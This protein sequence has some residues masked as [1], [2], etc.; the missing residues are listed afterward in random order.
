MKRT[1][2]QA[3]F[4]STE[5]TSKRLN[6]SAP[7]V[8]REGANPSLGVGKSSAVSLTLAGSS[9]NIFQANNTSIPKKS[10]KNQ[11]LLKY[12]PS[13]KAISPR[14]PMPNSRESSVQSWAS[15]V[16]SRPHL[17]RKIPI[18]KPTFQVKKSSPVSFPTRR[19]LEP[20][21]RKT[22]LFRQNETLLV[23]NGLNFRHSLLTEKPKQKVF[24]AS[25]Q[26]SSQPS[27]KILPY[28]G[29]F[30]LTPALELAKNFGFT[31]NEC[32]T[33]G[34]SELTLETTSGNH[35]KV[36]PKNSQFLLQQLKLQR[37]I[38]TNQLKVSEF[39]SVE[40][41]G[42]KKEF[43]GELNNL[44]DTSLVNSDRVLGTLR[45]PLIHQKA[46]RIEPSFQKKF[47]DL[48]KAIDSILSNPDS[49][50]IPYR[51]NDFLKQREENIFSLF[52]SITQL[53]AT[54]KSLGDAINQFEVA[55][56]S[57]FSG[58]SIV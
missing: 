35:P 41:I 12:T 21:P 39:L 8:L 19:A 51:F 40:N 38:L 48:F 10:F 6:G 2:A 16:L 14:I 28:L 9:K 7:T 17:S 11:D 4:S 27:T 43:L 45:H 34:N 42:V 32:T 26:P 36:Q 55:S 15:K 18:A 31:F 23:G 5:L 24:S 3:G 49:M 29:D 1:Y 46:L 54:L 57:L 47:S 58:E 25:S 56:S 13:T 33:K 50:V 53:S 52:D 44:I 20:S 30:T 22:K 37:D